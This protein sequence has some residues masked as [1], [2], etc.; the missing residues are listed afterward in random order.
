[1]YEEERQLRAIGYCRVAHAGEDTKEKLEYQK[2]RISQRAMSEDLELLDFYEELGKAG[3][4]LQELY[5]F[6]EEDND[7]NNILVSDFT[8]ISRKAEEVEAWISKFLELGIDI[9]W[10]DKSPIDESVSNRNKSLTEIYVPN[11]IGRRS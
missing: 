11:L 5:D 10:A 2:Q 3:E 8:R 9:L 4:V 7:I 6:C 1:M